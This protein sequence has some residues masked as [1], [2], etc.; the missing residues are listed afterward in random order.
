M[1]K[2][3]SAQ[4]DL[5]LI[6]DALCAGCYEPLDTIEI[7][8]LSHKLASLLALTSVGRV[9]ELCALS[10]AIVY[11]DPLFKPK[12]VTKSYHRRPVTF[13][14]FCPQPRTAE[15]VRLH[16]LCPVRALRVYVERTA[17]FRRS[18]QLFV[19]YGG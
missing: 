11:P 12:V 3:R 7:S 1:N 17:P 8:H 13:M 14:G 4:W 6:L 15:E 9:S 18:D 2:V 19:C 16:A 10:K 5:S